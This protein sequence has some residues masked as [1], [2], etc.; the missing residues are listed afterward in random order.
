MKGQG[1]VV[2][3]LGGLQKEQ[4]CLLLRIIIGD[5]KETDLGQWK[6]KKNNGK[7]KKTKTLSQ[8]NL[9]RNTFICQ[10]YLKKNYILCKNDL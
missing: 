2:L 8:K 9:S 3:L 6:K 7:K 10:R 5:E 1:S 4:R